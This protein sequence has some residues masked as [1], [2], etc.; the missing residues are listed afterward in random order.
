MSKVRLAA[1]PICAVVLCASVVSPAVGGPSI[2]SVANM[3]KKALRTGKSAKRAANSAKRT[4]N[5]ARTA[6]SSARSTADAAQS[7]A[8]TANGKADQALARPVVTPGV[9]TVVSAS[10]TIPANDFESVAAVCPSGQRVISGG[11]FTIAAAGGN[12]M[13]VAADDRTAWFAGGEDLGGAGGTV[14]AEAYCVPTGQAGAA[15]VNRAAIH[16][17]LRR[18]ER[19]KARASKP[20]SAGAKHAVLPDAS[21]KCLRAGQ[22]CSRKRAWQRTYHRTGLHCKRNGRL[23]YQ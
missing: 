5:A 22:F 2:T 23:T 16:G 8:G 19:Q 21:Y 17:E 3:A 1:V 4:A 10:A 14:T 20:C 11:A 7:L 15:K 18:H 13:N 9:I 12:W 6:A